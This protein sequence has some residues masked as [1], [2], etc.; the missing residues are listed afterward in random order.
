MKF[1]RF[2][3]LLL[4]IVLSCQAAASETR[5]ITIPSAAM[6]KTFNA[7]VILPDAY[8]LSTRRFPTVYLLHGWSGN[9]LDWSTKSDVARLADQYGLILVMP[10]GGY[11][12][13]YV[14]SP[15]SPGDKFETYVGKEVVASIDHDFRTIASKTA[16]GITGLSMGGFGALNIAAN[17]PDT[18]SVAGSIS[19]G[20]DPRATPH[21]W[22]I[23][24]AFGNRSQYADFWESKAIINNADRFLSNGVEIAIDCGVDDFMIEPNRALHQRLLALKIPHDYTER[25]GRHDWDYWNNAI[26]YQLLFMVTRFTRGQHDTGVSP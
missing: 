19:G 18:F 24:K 11:D 25:A 2:A 6:G 8:R 20:V 14:D 3:A 10:D 22:G 23:E 13:W 9:N 26:Q 12:K 5:Q 15:V 17:Y 4:T 1:N 7:T 21:S 16:R